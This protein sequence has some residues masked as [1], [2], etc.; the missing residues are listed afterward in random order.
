MTLPDY[1]NTDA[2]VSMTINGP[3]IAR[4]KHWVVK[5]DIS[6]TERTLKIMRGYQGAI[7][8]QQDFLND[9]SAFSSFLYALDSG[10]YTAKKR[11]PIGATEQGSCA[12]GQ[13]IIYEINEDGKQ[14]QHLWTTNC[15]KNVGTFNGN[16]TLTQSLFKAQIPDYNKATTG[17]NSH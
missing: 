9:Q 17:L 10:S 4:D 11:A 8:K 12:Q 2:V 7:E 5:I 6:R 15:T 14:K 1:A 16:N 13:R 3:I